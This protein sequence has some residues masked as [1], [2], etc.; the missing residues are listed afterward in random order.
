MLKKNHAYIRISS[1]IL[2]KKRY[3]DVLIFI[4]TVLVA[5]YEVGYSRAENSVP[6]DNHTIDKS[7]MMNAHS[8]MDPSRHS[9][10]QLPS[11]VISL[12][13]VEHQ[14][15]IDLLLAKN[16]SG[17]IT[18]WKQTSKDGGKTWLSNNEI[19]FLNEKGATV[20]RGSDA[21]LAII[22]N[23]TVAMWMSHVD[24]AKHGGAGP[25]VAVSSDN[26]GK[27]WS[28][29]QGPSDWAPGP[30][31]FFSL[32]SNANTIHAVWLDSRNGPSPAPGS[33][34]LRYAYSL[35][36]GN[37]WSKNITLDDISCACCWTTSKLDRHGNLYVLYRDKQP[38]DMSIGVVNAETHQWTKLS[39]VG[40]FG[41]DFAG[42][43]HI[44]GG[45]AI[46]ESKRGQ[47]L[48][49]VIGTRKK[50][51]AG[52]YYL[53]SIDGGK[54]WADPVR[55]GDKTAS[56]GD[57][58]IDSNGHL[59]AVW[60]MINNDEGDGSLG[61]Y[62]SETHDGINWTSPSRISSHHVS[63][64]HPRIITSRSGYLVL[65]TEKAEGNDQVLGT[66]LID[67]HKRYGAVAQ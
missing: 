38:S 67:I 13:A 17:L 36:A 12:D 4:T 39:T 10:M 15:I 37:S 14:G 47:E 65:W 50:E 2:A 33:Q 35:D 64:S 60:D 24:G 59:A 48:H 44:G 19:K 31:A 57:I 41:W 20:T 32:S 21:R 40:A 11:G 5:F 46:H 1:L 29:I 45:L 18:L 28:S 66:K 51:E 63:A 22:G 55:L 62:I 58:A 27:T 16:K 53:K 8:E 6:T 23:R 42:C 30:H 54:S 9:S 56:H 61:I 52:F 49:A 7:P 26:E 34:G 43:P 3:A 25:L